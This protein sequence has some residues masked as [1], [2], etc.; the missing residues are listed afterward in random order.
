MPNPPTKPPSPPKQPPRLNSALPARDFRFLHASG[1]KRLGFYSEP[2]ARQSGLARIAR[3]IKA[4]VRSISDAMWPDEDEAAAAPQ[5][6]PQ[7]A[8]LRQL[9]SA[10]FS[11]DEAVFPRL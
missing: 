1:I 5:L 3:E 7:I 8:K 6:D 9:C 4:A 10:G 2:F 11:H